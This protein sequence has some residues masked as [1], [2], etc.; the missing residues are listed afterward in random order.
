MRKLHRGV[1]DRAECLLWAVLTR[2]RAARCADAALAPRSAPSP[3][4]R[5]LRT[6]SM[7]AFVILALFL[8]RPTCLR[9][10]GFIVYPPILSLE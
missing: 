9:A 7:S 5:M 8:L 3:F 6:A 10:T 1:G 2:H 4:Y